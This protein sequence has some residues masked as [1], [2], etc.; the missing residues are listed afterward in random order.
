MANVKNNS[1]EDNND[2]GNEKNDYRC[3]IIHIQEYIP[4]QVGAGI[5]SFVVY[6]M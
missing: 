3:M 6:C 5:A 2:G 4:S 1:N